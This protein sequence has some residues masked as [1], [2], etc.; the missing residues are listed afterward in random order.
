MK[1]SGFYLTT[2]LVAG[3]FFGAQP[4]YAQIEEITVT[5]RK[6]SENLLQSPIAITAITAESLED[7]GLEDRREVL[8]QRRRGRQP[9]FGVHDPAQQ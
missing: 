3:V 9:A 4:S 5:A 6:T 7:K 8:A 2:A 1:R